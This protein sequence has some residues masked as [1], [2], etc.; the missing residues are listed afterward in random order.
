MTETLTFDVLARDHASQTF[1][2]V[3]KSTETLETR[4]TRLTRAATGIATTLVGAQL[5]KSV[6]EAADQF[7]LSRSRLETITKNIGANFEDLSKQVDAVDSQMEQFG[8]T[9]AQTEGALASLES[10]TRDPIKALKD[11][12]LA[13]DIA[14]GRN[15][16]LSEATLILQ[17]VETGHVAQLAKLGIATKDAAGH[18]LTQAQA[19]QMLA[20]LYGG[21]ASR[22]ADTLAGKQAAVGASMQ[23]TAAKI[24]VALLPAALDFAKVIQHDLLPPLQSSAEFLDRNRK[25]IEPLVK[26]LL[27]S[28]GAWKAYTIAT[29]LATTATRLFGASAVTA[30]GATTAEAAAAASAGKLIGTE[31]AAGLGVATLAASRLLTALKN[32]GPAVFGGIPDLGPK[33]QDLPSGAKVGGNAPQNVKDLINTQQNILNTNPAARADFRKTFDV[34]DTG[35]FSESTK[36][37]QAFIAK[38]Q[39]TAAAIHTAAAAETAFGAVTQR[40]ASQ[41]EGSVSHA[42]ALRS[43]QDG[44]RSAMHAA[45]QTAVDSGKA[46]VGNSDAALANRDAVRNEVTQI[47]AVID[48]MKA[49][50]ASDADQKTMLDILTTALE[51]NATKLYGDKTAV[52]ALLKSLGLLPGAAR[53]A[54]IAIAQAGVVAEKAHLNQ[55][56]TTDEGPGAA[57]RLKSAQAQL[58]AGQ[59]ALSAAKASGKAVADSFTAGYTPV[60]SKAAEKAAKAVSDAMQKARDKVTNDLQTIR[61]AISS[62]QG[63]IAGFADFTAAGTDSLGASGINTDVAS[64]LKG[65]AA[66]LEEFARLFNRL[67]RAGLDAHLMAQFAQIGP[68]AIPAMQALLRSGKRGI[69]QVNRIETRINAAAASVAQTSTQEQYS[70]QIH[71]DL[72]KLP[73]KLSRVLAKDLKSVHFSVSVREVDR[74]NGIAVVIAP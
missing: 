73:P 70:R 63:N 10:V 49:R 1:N 46:L 19:L 58:T 5:G 31:M 18:T 28:V 11:L 52:D 25:V 45:A 14:R 3:A 16:G 37:M 13:A 27:L 12:A 33:T 53:N 21:A 67:D 69:G 17:R 56:L 32:L 59:Q 24:G 15:I 23:D 39:Q 26:A 20:N 47:F 55:L 64:Q 43:A 6:L 9:N 30:A 68:D 36:Q 2:R 40:T 66:K 60:V 41:I 35:R 38:W 51:N 48:A 62:T 22:Y 7:E 8:Y 54:A 29:S 71:D 61:D 4:F 65:K 57:S 50:H 44:L 34:G 72:V 74:K 42:L